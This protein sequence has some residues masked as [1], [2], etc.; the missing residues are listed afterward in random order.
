MMGCRCAICENAIG[1]ATM[2][3]QTA[4]AMRLAT[5]FIDS[6]LFVVHLG[7]ATH[8]ERLPVAKSA[9][10]GAKERQDNVPCG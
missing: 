10:F 2:T 5:F 7:F 1:A 9:Q 8:Q 3:V 6:L 4:T